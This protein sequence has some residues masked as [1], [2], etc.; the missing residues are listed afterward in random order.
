MLYGVSVIVDIQY[1]PCCRVRNVTLRRQLSGASM[2]GLYGTMH[3]CSCIFYKHLLYLATDRLPPSDEDH[4]RLIFWDSEAFVVYVLSH[5]S[6][7]TERI[8]V[9][10]SCV[11]MEGVIQ[12][13]VQWVLAFF[14][15]SVAT[16]LG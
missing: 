5:N 13:T 7:T 10:N 14:P 8:A 4:K 2:L 12:P 15:C 6:I 3:S 9:A 1:P 11:S 16:C